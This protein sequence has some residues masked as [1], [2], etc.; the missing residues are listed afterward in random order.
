MSEQKRSFKFYLLWALVLV[1]AV[2]LALCSLPLIRRLMDPR[3]ASTLQDWVSN[4]GVWGVV[5]LF[6]IQVLQIV[7]AFLPGE[8]VELVAG[9]LYGALGGLV[10][11]LVGIVVGSTL[12]FLTVRRLGRHRLQ[13]DGKL[14]SQM[15]RYQFLR[16]EKKLETLIF[17]LYLI[18]GTPKDILVYVSALTNITLGRFLA[19]STL[20]RV[21]SVLTSTWAGAAFAS[22]N[23]GVTLG[24]FAVTGLLGL[25]GIFFQDRLLKHKNS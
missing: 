16:N 5:G 17:L 22:G 6:A 11:C 14:K 12:V 7:V 20:A 25:G 18:P 21:P 19:L 24:I 4:L 13:Q 8:P 3:V 1:L 10:I 2:V 15:A 9:T 23:W